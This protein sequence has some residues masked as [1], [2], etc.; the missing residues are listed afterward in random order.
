MLQEVLKAL[1]E[2]ACTSPS[3]TALIRENVSEE[4]ALI[5]SEQNSE[6]QPLHRGGGNLQLAHFRTHPRESAPPTESCRGS[7]QRS[8]PGAVAS[9]RASRGRMA[10][11]GAAGRAE[12]AAEK[13]DVTVSLALLSVVVLLSDALRRMLARVLAHSGLEVHAAEFVST[14]QLCCCTHELRVL[15]DVG[16]IERRLAHTLT[17]VAAVVHGLTFKGAVGNPACTLVHT[18]RQRLVPGAALW[19]IACQFAAAAAARALMPLAWSLGMSS[20]HVRHRAR[21]FQCTSPVDSPL[22]AT[23]VETAC[24][25]AVQTAITQ[26]R[27]LEEKYRVHAV[28]AVVTT[29]VYAGGPS[30]GA[31]F[32]PAL[33]FSTQ[34]RCEGRSLPEYCLVYWLGPVLGML[35]SVLLCDWLEGWRLVRRR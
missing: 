20:L 9:D 21:E 16:K 19:E 28:A 7:S 14:L 8:G 27:S 22:I 32:N 6:L 3:Q 13:A 29:A 35:G 4:E 31:V 2:R 15:S 18:Y 24:A 30:T 23:A 12:W 5:S 17:Y 34:F 11:E 25:C 33:A 1:G 26:T 10:G